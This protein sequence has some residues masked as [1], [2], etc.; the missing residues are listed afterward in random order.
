MYNVMVDKVWFW[1]SKSQKAE[2][3]IILLADEK[4]G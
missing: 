2:G 1:F 4:E 3:L